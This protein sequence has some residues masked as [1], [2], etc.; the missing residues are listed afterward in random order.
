MNRSLNRPWPLYAF[1]L[2]SALATMGLLIWPHETPPP[3]GPNAPPP[4]V[5]QNHRLRTV[6][7]SS[8]APPLRFAT[9]VETA[10]EPAPT[11]APTLVGVLAGQAAWLRSTTSGAVE[12]VGSGEAFEGWRLRRVF[13]TSVTVSKGAER[14]ELRLYQSAATTA[15]PVGS[16]L[17]PDYMNGLQPPNPTVS[18]PRP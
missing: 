6:A 15:S 9:T 2:A 5:G 1:G 13:E 8:K 12:R 11:S 14:R 7:P 4:F 18:A 17:R 10:A 3:S 16:A